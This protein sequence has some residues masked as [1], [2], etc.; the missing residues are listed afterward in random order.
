[1]AVA[2]REAAAAGS[3]GGRAA[4]GLA[5][6]RRLL[7]YLRPYR[8]HFILG[9][10]GGVLFSA[11]MASFALFARAFGDGTFTHRDPRTIVWVPLALVGL[12]ILRGIGDFTQTYFMGYV[13]R[14]IVNALRREVFQRI[15]NLPIGYFDRN[16]S[17]AL[18]SKLTYNTEQIGQATTDAVITVVRTALTIVASIAFLLWLNPRLTLI[19]LTMG[20]LVGW[21]VSVINRRFR[22][23]SRR[24]QDSMGDVTRVAKESF[25]APRL[26]KV[27]NA[28]DHL[29]QQF[30][31]V[32]NH[33]LRSNMR[34]VLTRGLSNPVVQLLTAVGLSFV[35]SIAI[36]D[37][38]HARM[39]MGDL[40]GFFTALVS[41]AQPLRELVGVAG[42]LQQGIAAG[43][44][45]FEVLDE[46][47][48]PAGG[49]LALA[50]ARGE[51]SFNAVQ[52]SYGQRELAPAVAAEQGV[53][54]QRGLEH[55]GAAL[56]D[57][58]LTVPAGQ[59][60]AI[61]G[62]SGSGKSTLVNLLPRFYDVTAGSVAI[63]GHDVRD[64]E[65]HDLREQIAV[66][67]QDVVLFND[68]IRNNIAFG[69]DVS[70]E[71]IER[72]AEA[73]H[74]LEFIRALPAGLDTMVGDRGM[75]LS[76]GQRQRLAIARALLK[77]A[78]ILILDEATSALDTE[79]ERHIQAALA[80]LMRNRTTFVIAHRL[81]TVEQADRIVVLDAGAVCES[82]THAQL[83]A[84]AGLYAQLHRLQ[85][86][87]GV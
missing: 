13:G 67:S 59:S 37:A 15:L 72:A 68:T 64:Y 33:N 5:A 2:A 23:Y 77:D 56:R 71:A 22:R 48:E 28:Q 8:G 55:R 44:S 20:P 83:L 14:H 69:R 65:L 21:L 86:S 11:T 24:I 9:L 27:Y 47:P 30:D 79:S 58:T 52:F 40:L 57:I 74:A 75:L 46:A 36:A 19:A 76:G 41:I 6:Y 4:G 3:R 80:H 35:L 42:P 51:V 43:Q 60:L 32:N 1:M 12:F 85:F 63:D 87:D 61:V 50:R 62:R 78:P 82:G 66:V 29:L 26:I 16:S 39:S 34:L 73:A 7:G 18:L 38:V 53:A 25:E 70:D 31:A 10:L 17:A 81:S 54:A 84:H 45:I 49:S